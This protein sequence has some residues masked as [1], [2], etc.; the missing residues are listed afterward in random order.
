MN[1]TSFEAGKRNATESRSAVAGGTLYAQIASAQR[2][3]QA[4]KQ[5]AFAL[6]SF[7]PTAAEAAVIATSLK[8]LHAPM[9]AAME[10]AYFENLDPNF[11]KE[12]IANNKNRHGEHFGVWNKIQGIDPIGSAAELVDSGIELAAS[13]ASKILSFAG[14]KLKKHLEDFY[15]ARMHWYMNIEKEAMSI[16]VNHA[17]LNGQEFVNPQ[18]YSSL[19]GHKFVQTYDTPIDRLQ[20]ASKEVMRHMVLAHELKTMA[21]D[22][23]KSLGTGNS[24]LKKR[25]ESLIGRL[26]QSAEQRGDQMVWGHGCMSSEVHGKIARGSDFDSVVEKDFDIKVLKIEKGQQPSA[27]KEITRAT[28]RDLQVV[29]QYVGVAKKQLENAIKENSKDLVT[30]LS[31]AG[32]HD[33]KLTPERVNGVKALVLFASRASEL[34]AMNAQQAYYDAAANAV[35]WLKLSIRDTERVEQREKAEQA[36]QQEQDA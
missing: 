29:R 33:N 15:D 10:S 36:R 31:N 25:V 19:T 16:P 28:T 30:A 21:L 32:H 9:S 8:L 7:T 3:Q 12:T 5:I 17:G 22:T 23:A 18:M 27:S 14:G 35:L 26:R 11:E 1:N 2:T 34:I 13:A 6:E 4:C 20:D 24:D